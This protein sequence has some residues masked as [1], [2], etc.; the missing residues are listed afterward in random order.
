MRMRTPLKFWSLLWPTFGR[1]PLPPRPR[2]H[3]TCRVC[4]HPIADIRLKL[5]PKAD[6]CAPCQKAVDARVLVRRA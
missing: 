2:A 1:A 6:L 4:S 5:M 3:G